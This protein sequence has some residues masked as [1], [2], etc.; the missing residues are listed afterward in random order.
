MRDQQ[1]PDRLGRTLPRDLDRGQFHWSISATPNE[2]KIIGR[3]EVVSRSARIS[4]SYSC[5]TCCPDSGPAGSFDPNA[6]ILAVDGFIYTNAHGD[7]YDCYSNHYQGSLSWTSMWTNDTSIATVNG[8]TGQLHGIGL[9][10]TNVA[11]EYDIVSWSTDGMDC[12]RQYGTGSDNAPVLVSPVYLI[13]TSEVGTTNSAAF[14][15]GI[16]FASLNI[17]SCGGERFGIKIRFDLAS[18]TTVSNVDSSVTS[19][20][21]FALAPS[22]VDG[23]YVEYYGNGHPPYTITYLKKVRTSGNRAVTHNI[24]GTSNGKSFTTPVSVTLVCH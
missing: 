5:P 12:Y 21:M 15:G 13:D 17:S 19:T 14:L 6:Y 18:N 24:T 8:G 23:T 3:A 9:G 7:Y 1:Q 4:S 22:P 20:G 11:G 16:P 2:P 10:G